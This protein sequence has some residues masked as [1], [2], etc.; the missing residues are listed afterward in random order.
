MFDRLAHVTFL[1][2]ILALVA[3]A[4]LTA[5]Q[6]AIT[7]DILATFDYPLA[8]GITSPQGINERGDV[9]GFYTDAV[10]TRGFL[11]LRNGQFSPP[12]IDP[13]DPGNFTQGRDLNDAREVCGYFSEPNFSAFHG[14]FFLNGTFTTYDVPGATATII[15]GL[16]NAGRVCG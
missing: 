5:E 10:G 4:P 14:F 8:T 16:N 6:P 15:T 3:A 7:I 11:R 13:G 9:S 2:G 1:A 12:L